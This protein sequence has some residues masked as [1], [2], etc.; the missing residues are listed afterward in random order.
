MNAP[1]PTPGKCPSC[2]TQNAPDTKFCGE[3]GT[4]L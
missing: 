4:K 3:C 1:A 2:G